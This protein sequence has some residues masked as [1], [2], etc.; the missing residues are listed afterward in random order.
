MRFCTNAAGEEDQ[1]SAVF[2]SA[3]APHAGRA[4]EAPPLLR[5]QSAAYA[6]YGTGGAAVGAD[7]GA[8]AQ[9]A[10]EAAA[11]P[12]PPW[13]RAAGAVAADPERE[14]LTTGSMRLVSI[15][16]LGH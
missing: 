14:P 3:A 12:E 15:D 8:A 1:A 10:A 13:G 9:A 16:Q 4:A 7:A 2:A 11:P 6:R 5:P